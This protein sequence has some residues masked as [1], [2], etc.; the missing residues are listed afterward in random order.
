MDMLY[1]AYS[2]YIMHTAYTPN[3]PQTCIRIY[4]ELIRN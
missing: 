2:E 4:T 3:L 1:N